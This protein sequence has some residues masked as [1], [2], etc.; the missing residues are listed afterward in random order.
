[1]SSLRT[2][3]RVDIKIDQ[4]W[5]IGAAPDLHFRPDDQDVAESE[6]TIRLPVQRDPSGGYLLPATSLVGS[7]G[8]HLGKDASAWLGSGDGDNAAPSE[9]RCLSATIHNVAE[10]P[11]EVSTTAIDEAR[12]AAEQHALRTE[13]LLEP[14]EVTWW[15][16]WDHHDEGLVLVDL[17]EK[18]ADW[19]PIVG[20]HRSANRGRAFVQDVHHRTL[21]LDNDADLTWWLAERPLFDW[22]KKKIDL[23]ELGWTTTKGAHG[24]N[25]GA[26]LLSCRFTVQDALHIGGLGQRV[27]ENDRKITRTKETLPGTSWRG[28]FRH[29]MRHIVRVTSQENHDVEATTARLFGSP[30]ASGAS[31]GFGHR[32]QL[33]F[34]DSVVNGTVRTRTHVAIDR[35]TGG[36]AELHAADPLDDV[37]LLFTLD[38]Y[39]PG[40]TLELVIYNDSAQPVSPGDK[41]LLE[42]VIR[43]IDEAIIGVGGMTSRGYGTLKMDGVI[44]WE[45]DQS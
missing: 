28:V 14:A 23:K 12:R 29:R 37:G 11:T 25:E 31:K 36:A 3:I 21:D 26:R 33:R 1:M 13:E 30:R 35:I 8:R 5:A 18:L 24:D 6:R 15:L 20:R 7:L 9:L 39:G 44:K 40:A 38:H 2:L 4:Q 17:I 10:R 45:E 22:G 19:R 34:G 27:D 43:D 42:A 32:G 41:R 16:E